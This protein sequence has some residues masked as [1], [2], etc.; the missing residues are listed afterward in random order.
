MLQRISQTHVEL[1][2]TCLSVKEAP[3]PLTR[4]AGMKVAA[5]VIVISVQV[6]PLKRD[7]MLMKHKLLVFLSGEMIQL[8]KLKK[9]GKP[10]K[11]FTLHESTVTISEGIK[12]LKEKAKKLAGHIF[13]TYQQWW[14]KKIT[15]EN[16]AYGTLCLVA[17]YQQNLRENSLRS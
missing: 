15:V 8:Q 2:P 13:V 14:A 3:I 17:D 1:P 10:R 16:L 7:K 11:V 6:S 4:L 12:L 5:L 9:D